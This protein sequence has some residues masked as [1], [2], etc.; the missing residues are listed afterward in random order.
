MD[1]R[2]TLSSHKKYSRLLN[3]AGLVARSHGYALRH[4]LPYLESHYNPRDWNEIHPTFLMALV[5][6]ADYVQIEAERA[7]SESL[8]FRKLRSPISRREWDVHSAVDDIQQVHADP[9][10]VEIR[11]IP[12]SVRTVT[13]IRQWE[14]GFQSE[15]DI[16][17]AVLGEVYGRYPGLNKLGLV[18]R[19]VRSNLEREDFGNTLSFVPKAV[20]FEAAGS[21][22]LKLL[23]Q[24]LYG[25]RP[26]IGVRELLQNAVDAVLELRQYT[27][28][29][30]VALDFNK[31]K[32]DVLVVVEKRDDGSWWL[33]ISDHGIGM[34]P[35]IVCDYFL[36]VG[37]SFRKST[38]WRNQF[39]GARGGAEIARSGR[40]GIGVLA[41]FLLGPELHL[42]T[43]HVESPRDRGIR[44]S[45]TMDESDV[46][47]RWIER[48]VGTT[49]RI[50]LTEEAARRIQD[51]NTWDWYC[52]FDPTV[53]RIVVPEVRL[54]PQ[55]YSAPADWDSNL[56]WRRF[57]PPRFHRVVWSYNSA[58]WLICNGFKIVEKA[59]D[60]SRDLGR[61]LS[62]RI[63]NLSVSDPDGNLP[64]TLQRT[65][66]GDELPFLDELWGEVVKDI[67]AFLLVTL[68]TAPLSDP[69]MFGRYFELN[70]EGVSSGDRQWSLF[71]SSEQGIS[72]FEDS[73]LL[74]QGVQ[75]LIVIAAWENYLSIP[76]L[77]TV[78]RLPTVGVVL[79]SSDKGRWTVSVQRLLEAA[80]TGVNGVRFQGVRIVITGTEQNRWAEDLFDKHKASKNV[81]L[82]EEHSGFQIWAIGICLPR[83]L[84]L[85][86]VASEMIIQREAEFGGD[87]THSGLLCE[88]YLL[89]GR[90]ALP[91][92]L[93]GEAWNLYISDP[94]IPF[95]QEE[96][97]RRYGM[98]GE[99][100]EFLEL[101][102][103]GIG[104]R[105]WRVP[106]MPFDPPFSADNYDDAA[107]TFSCPDCASPLDFSLLSGHRR[108]E[109]CGYIDVGG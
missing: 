21:E 55:R 95:G 106:L 48:P 16:T 18:I 20:S 99:L 108:C 47:M 8:R 101:H 102:G 50:R 103:A 44:F 41:A 25:N 45:V 84:D 88:Y 56:K 37:A 59:P 80:F 15:M 62:V 26:E 65:E 77:E 58:P 7:P 76:K 46:E 24:P 105:A 60:M 82:E 100:A 29:R 96:R 69:R 81:Q 91:L 67:V 104:N 57:S 83:E 11:W 34:N 30:G 6:I 98:T 73:F 36:R 66:L 9:E 39:I 38:W 94:Y 92:S 49:I 86:A 53:V 93:L 109:A 64:L 78:A 68:P 5:R 42:S 1:G 22:I 79:G 33:V 10:S 32:A 107:D 27:V 75:R 12:D 89:P 87:I 4:F 3:L 2:I 14:A 40:F 61:H 31:H 72:P 13:R 19:R 70:H 51:G 52:W 17:W 43:R 90:D 85:T 97:V 28:N 23:I 71:F 54:L 35:D 63:P 74:S